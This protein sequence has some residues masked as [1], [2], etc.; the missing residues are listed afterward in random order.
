[1]Q[2]MQVYSALANNGQ[3]VKP[4]LVEKI[5]DSSDKT[6][7]SYKVQ[8]VG[9][10]ILRPRTRKVVVQNMKKVLDKEIGTGHIYYMKARTSGSRPGRLRLPSQPAAT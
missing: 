1:M 3:M 8:K 6:V 2:M 7:K 4:Q 10:K 9:K 5:T